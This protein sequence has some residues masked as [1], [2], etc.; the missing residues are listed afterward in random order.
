MEILTKKHVQLK[1][2]SDDVDLRIK[3]LLQV[4]GSLHNDERLK[5]LIRYY[6]K[7]VYLIAVTRISNTILNKSGESGQPCF[8]PDLKGKLFNFFPSSMM[9]VVGFSYMAFIMLRKASF[10]P[11]LLSVYII[12]GYCTLSNVF[13]VSTDMVYDFCLSFFYVVY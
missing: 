1:L 10:I 13:L 4:I 6:Y 11:T 7:C 5:S 2:I 12:N 3:A 8:L 9:L